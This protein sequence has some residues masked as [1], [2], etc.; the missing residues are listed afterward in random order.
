MKNTHIVIEV[1]DGRAIET[2]LPKQEAKTLY[3]K[4]KKAGAEAIV[5]EYEN[6]PFGHLMAMSMIA[7]IEKEQKE[8]EMKKETI[9]VTKE[10]QALTLSKAA[11]M[12]KDTIDEVF[13]ITEHKEPFPKL[14]DIEWIKVEAPEWFA[15]SMIIGSFRISVNKEVNPAYWTDEAKEEIIPILKDIYENSK[16]LIVKYGLNPKCTGE[17][18]GHYIEATQ[19]AYDKLIELGYPAY[20]QSTRV[21]VDRF[22]N[23]YIDEE[24]AIVGTTDC[25]PTHVEPFY[26]HNGEFTTTPPNPHAEIKAEYEKAIAEDKI[27]KLYAKGI[28]EFMEVKENPEWIESLEYEL[29]YYE[30]D[31]KKLLAWSYANDTL[32]ECEFACFATFESIETYKILAYDGRSFCS[33]NVDGEWFAYCRLVKDTEIKDEWLSEIK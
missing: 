17:W 1:I 19:E 20:N 23:Y 6:N 5:Y 26:L 31:W 25:D 7:E 4:L 11:G 18:N 32:V 24:G 30:I 29:R 13:K 28:R 10:R 2:R 16:D 8:N 9:D 14:D 15:K 3:D 22:K 27:V 12:M 33:D 21:E